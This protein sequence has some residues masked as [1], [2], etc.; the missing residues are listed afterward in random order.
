MS[1]GLSQLLRA[2]AGEKGAQ[3]WRELSVVRH[4]PVF[5]RASSGM[6]TWHCVKNKGAPVCNLA[7]I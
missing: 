7:D 6:F 2:D 5:C 1:G 4:A 3:D